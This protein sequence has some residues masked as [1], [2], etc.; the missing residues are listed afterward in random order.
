MRLLDNPLRNNLNNI[1][2]NPGASL[3]GYEQRDAGG[4]SAGVRVKH[5][6]SHDNDFAARRELQN[7]YYFL[8]EGIPLIYSDAYN[9]APGD[10]PF[11]RHANAPFLGQF[12]DNKMPDLACTRFG[13]DA[14]SHGS[15][16]SL[17]KR[18]DVVRY[19]QSPR[20]LESAS[21]DS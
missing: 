18:A 19:S 4:F 9:E 2:G 8:R 5:A 12:N 21:S 6:Q 17:A 1:L 13:T 14:Q 20:H 16:R 10:H 15:R 7:A 11:P 3:A